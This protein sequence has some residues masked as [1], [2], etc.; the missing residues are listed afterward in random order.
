MEYA[1]NTRHARDVVSACTVSAARP[2]SLRASGS[3]HHSDVGAPSTRGLMCRSLSTRTVM[4]APGTRRLV[5]RCDGRSAPEAWCLAVAGP[6]HYRLGARLSGCSEHCK[7]GSTAA[8]LGT[9]VRRTGAVEGASA[10]ESP[11]H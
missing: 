6:Q 4:R 2:L 10:A 9:R 5:A 1:W 8:G 11:S 3:P 7:R